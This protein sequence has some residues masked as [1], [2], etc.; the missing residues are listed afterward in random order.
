MKKERSLITAK[1]FLD[2]NPGDIVYTEG[3]RPRK[4]LRKFSN[5]M[6]KVSSEWSKDGWSI[7]TFAD[8]IR[9]YTSP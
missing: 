9:L 2:L 5:N 3:G 8:R 6:V 1:E 7:Y 4:V